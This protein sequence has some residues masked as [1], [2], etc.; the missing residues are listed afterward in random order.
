MRQRE[1]MM[2]E[3]H[4]HEIELL[5]EISR[6]LDHSIDLREVADPILEA[7]SLH[8][9]MEFATLTLLHKD[10][11]EIL[12]EASRGLSAQQAQRGKYHLGEGI[13]G[14][15]VATGKAIVVRKTSESPYYLDKTKRGRSPDRSFL[16]VPIMVERTVAG[17]LS[18]DLPCEPLGELEQDARLLRIVASMIAQA[19]KLRRAVMA[20]QDRLTEENRR[21]R[22]DLAERY[23]PGRVLGNSKAMR[24]VYVRMAELTGHARAVWF[25]GEAG[26]GK[27]TLARAIHFN[28]PRAEQPFVTLRCAGMAASELE[29]ELF[30]REAA[31][32]KS[33]VGRLEKAAGGTFYVADVEELP[34]AAQERLAGVLAGRGFE[35]MG[36]TR[37]IKMDVRVM[38][39]SAADLAGLAA[40]GKF[41]KAL[42]DELSGG[43]L[44]V[45]PLRKRRTDIPLL[46]DHFAKEHAHAHGKDVRRLSSATIDM[47]MAYHWP[48]NVRELEDVI[49]EAVLAAEGTVILPYHLPPTLQTA[50][51]TDAPWREGSDSAQGGSRSPAGLRSASRSG[52]APEQSLK[53]RVGAFERDIILDALKSSR[54]NMAGAA[55]MLRTTPRILA[56]K[57][58]LHGIKPKAYL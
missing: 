20:D 25:D 11:D 13:T 49:E 3:R 4:L 22:A 19:T 45:P 36:G 41:S 54:G 53:Q 47:L 5:G 12:I 39:G 14:R 44:F 37:R 46:A 32:G 15:V 10:T 31:A 27:E 33:V 56:Y 30:G 51:A 29:G 40:E 6:L 43:R 58:R 28:G 7:L 17:A 55:R 38:V 16:C 21:L 1:A 18:V 48:A 35:R 26:T 8:M 9:G 42:L 2:R 24:E 50:E 57:V 34:L 52:A 23:R